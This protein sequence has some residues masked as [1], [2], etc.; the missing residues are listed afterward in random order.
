MVSYKVR[1][2]HA[3]KLLLVGRVYKLERQRGVVK[4]TFYFCGYYA[5]G[6][7]REI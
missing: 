5:K 1:K 2:G 7:H 3:S 6:L 4:N